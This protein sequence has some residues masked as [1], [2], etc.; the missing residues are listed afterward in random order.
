[1]RPGAQ[2]ADRFELVRLLK[3]GNGVST[4]LAVDGRSGR[5]AVL[6]TFDPAAINAAVP[7]R[8]EHE[9]RV[10]R[11]LT[12]A[13]VCA[14]LDAGEADGRLYLAQE[15][16]PGSPLDEA[17]ATGPLSVPATLRVGIALATA[18]E[19]AH[20]AGVHHRDVKPGNVI[21]DGRRPDGSFEQVTL[22]DFGLA[23]SP[24]LDESI[25]DELVGTVRYLSPESAGLLPTPADERADLYSLGV[26][27]YEC[28]AGR[29]PFDAAAVG[30]LLRQ[31]LSAPVPDL[32][33]AVPEVPRALAAAVHRLLRKDPAE[34][35]QTAAA[36]AGD[37]EHLLRAIEAG[38]PDP[39]LVIGRSDRR[40]TVTDPAFVGREAEL[41]TLRSF[42]ADLR[43]GGGGCLL[44]DA[45]SGGGK[46][47]LLAELAASA[48][49]PVLTGQGI[50]HGGQRPFTLLHGVADGLVEL[51]AG[52]PPGRA[53]LAA[54]V[55]DSA[56][57]IVRA[58]PALGSLLGAAAAADSG[59][60]EFGE[61][62]SLAGLRRLLAAAATGEHPLL[63]ILDDCQWA[64]VLT[65]RL[66]AEL[67]AEG[68]PA[69]PH[70]GVIAAFRSE[71]VPADHALRAIATARRMHLGPLSNRSVALLVESMAGAVPAAATD[72]VVRLADGNP[73]MAAAVLRGLVES[74][75]IVPGPAGWAV[76]A[77]RLTDAQAARRSAAFLVRRLELLAPE[78]LELLSVGAV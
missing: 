6:K 2:F 57:A 78:S 48:G 49:V 4:H 39:S 17:L 35:Y 40:A 24:W 64:D 11:E 33:V 70:L 51:F 29:P 23:R 56:P 37:L 71:E 1:M 54:E 61:L 44:L 55:A 60:E 53:A 67:F 20:A 68:E 58:L 59:P 77:S 38:N 16:V 74:A 52:D 8:F 34:R 27:L 5:P 28:L 9:T 3:Q 18:L 72:T 14:L 21:V 75:A 45:D 12:G 69:P 25:R 73:F 19:T 13:G 63:I 22:I 36:V 76:D 26:V 46:S 32:R 41:A 7:A 66:L 65:V 62:R 43:R 42:T 30:D 47:R 15:Y 50:A 10:L 31:H